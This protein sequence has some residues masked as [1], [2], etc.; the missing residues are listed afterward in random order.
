[1]WNMSAKE[2]RNIIDLGPSPTFDMPLLMDLP[3]QN[4]ESY[5]A[6][7]FDSA[8]RGQL[9]RMKVWLLVGDASLPFCIAAL[10]SVQDDDKARGSGN[11]NYEVLHDVNHFVSYHSTIFWFA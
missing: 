8:V 4:H 6:A 11:V 7:T 2:S 5:I 10:W 9:P 3:Q 1:M